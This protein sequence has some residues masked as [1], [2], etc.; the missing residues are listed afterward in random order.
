[1][2]LFPAFFAVFFYLG[3]R[4][5][6][7]LPLTFHCYCYSIGL[8][9]YPLV[10]SVLFGFESSVCPVSKRSIV[11]VAT[12]IW[13]CSNHCAIFASQHSIPSVSF[14]IRL[15]TIAFGYALQIVFLD[16]HL[17]LYTGG[18]VSLVCIG[19]LIQGM[20]T[21]CGKKGNVDLEKPIANQNEEVVT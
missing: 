11:I 18:A 15:L 8:F 6:P 10:T 9:L 7:K 17:T 20:A 12:F 3:I 13:C 2:L 1:M 5:H 19:V 4:S 14:V 16:E 21:A